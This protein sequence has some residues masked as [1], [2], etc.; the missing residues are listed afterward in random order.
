MQELSMKNGRNGWGIQLK[1]TGLGGRNNR[2][3][4]KMMIKSLQKYYIKLAVQA[5][6][7]IWI[8]DDTYQALFKRI[9]HENQSEMI[10]KIS[11]KITGVGDKTNTNDDGYRPGCQNN[12]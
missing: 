6:K 2:A 5:D 4:M 1:T 10:P 11:Y 9:I 7:I 8:D 3:S 12:K